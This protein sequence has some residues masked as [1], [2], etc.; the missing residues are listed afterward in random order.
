MRGGFMSQVEAE[1]RYNMI[2]LNPGEA[3]VTYIGFQEILDIERD[4]RK[5]KGDAFNT[6]E[7]LQKILSYGAVPFRTLKAKLVQ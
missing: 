7:F 5:L 6:R 4:Y 3:A 2:V 1:R